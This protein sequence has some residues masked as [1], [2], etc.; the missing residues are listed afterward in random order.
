MIFILSNS[1]CDDSAPRKYGQHV[2]RTGIGLLLKLTLD[3]SAV[4]EFSIY[5]CC[6]RRRT[7]LFLVTIFTNEGVWWVYDKLQTCLA[8]ESKFTHTYPFVHSLFC[9]SVVYNYMVLTCNP[10]NKNMKRNTYI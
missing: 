9:V 2:V 1:S 8:S 4:N 6:S 7:Y 10:R 5:I 3:V